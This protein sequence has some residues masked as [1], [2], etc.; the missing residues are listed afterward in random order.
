M[1]TQSAGVAA[2]E[3]AVLACQHHHRAPRPTTRTGRPRAI[4]VSQHQDPRRARAPSLYPGPAATRTPIWHRSWRCKTGMIALA[5]LAA[6]A[7]CPPLSVESPNASWATCYFVTPTV[8]A[9]RHCLDACGADAAPACPAS[10]EEMQFLTEV[11]SSVVVWLGYFRASLDDPE[12]SCVTPGRSS[13]IHWNHATQ[14]LE[15]EHCMKYQDTQTSNEPC[16]FE[17]HYK[18]SCLCA[19]G[20]TSS[21]AARTDLLALEAPAA[22]WMA[23]LRQATFN[24]FAA[25]ILIGIVPSCLLLGWFARAKLAATRAKASSNT[26]SPSASSEDS[27]ALA[28]RLQTAQKASMSVRLR[29]SGILA[30]VGWLFLCV[31]LGSFFAAV[32]IDYDPVMGSYVIYLA[33]FP[34]GVV[35][36]FMAVLPTDG[37]AIR[38]LCVILCFMLMFFSLM[39]SLLIL[40]W[41]ANGNASLFGIASLVVPVLVLLAM[42]LY[43]IPTLPRPECCGCGRSAVTARQSLRRLWLLFRCLLLILGLAS[44]TLP[45]RPVLDGKPHLFW[46]RPGAVSVYSIFPSLILCGCVP[47]P[48]IRGRVMRWLSSLGAGNRRSSEHEAALIA[49]LIGGGDPD[50]VLAEGTK[51]FRGMPF[52]SLTAS[53]LANNSDTGMFARTTPAALGEVSAFVS[54][55]WSDD[56]DAKMAQLSEWASAEESSPVLWLGARQASRSNFEPTPQRHQRSEKPVCVAIPCR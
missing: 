48:R 15:G 25:L 55:S 8:S 53:D 5:F 18:L 14:L 20:F 28:S 44:W 42:A 49:G 4:S 7:S 13:T 2:G 23:N 27:G 3:A 16:I 38:A 30:C 47:T 41:I 26:L 45:M 9:M 46:Y 31:G 12:W 19:V 36:M 21:P 35:L 54:H 33:F 11:T 1:V 39:L 51:N 34:W 50:A 37:R 40:A 6:A 29:T 17:S 43:L 52:A 32:R 10:Q 24:I 22:Q 56:G